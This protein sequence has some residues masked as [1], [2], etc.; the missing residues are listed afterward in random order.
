MFSGSSGDGTVAGRW[1]L[2]VDSGHFHGGTTSDVGTNYGIEIFTPWT[3]S[4]IGTNWIS[5][6]STI[7]RSPRARKTAPIYSAG[8]TCAFAG[9]VGIGTTAPGY[10]RCRSATPATAARRAN[11]WNLLSSM[12]VQDRRRPLDETGYDDILTKIE[13]TDVVHYRYVDDDHR[14]LGVIAEDG[15][16][17][18]P[19]ARQEGRE[20]GRLLGLLP[21]RSS[22]RS[23]RRFA[24]CAQRSTSCA[25]WRR[26]CGAD[27]AARAQRGLAGLGIG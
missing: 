20:P 4:P 9:N 6:S 10:P 8:G 14:H 25:P 11:A 3:D 15:E 5:L 18:D 19:L 7:R 27:L 1:S 26:R 21:R 17:G 22:R 13:H 23:R 12:R 16:E 24:R 2:A